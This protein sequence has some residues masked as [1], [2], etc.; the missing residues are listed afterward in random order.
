MGRSV[1]GSSWFLWRVGYAVAGGAV[2][3]SSGVRRQRAP[4]WCVKRLR[5]GFGRAVVVKG[6]V[7]DHGVQERLFRCGFKYVECECGG[8][9]LLECF[10]GSP[11]GGA[12]EVL[13]RLG[14]GDGLLDH[15][16]DPVDAPVRFLD[17]LAQF[18]VGGFLCGV[19]VPLPA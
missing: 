17:L 10:Q 14:V 5:V 6:S 3:C 11:V 2:V 18:A 15:L 8:D 9:S 12:E 1:I 19:I 4:M 13:R 7:T 16:T